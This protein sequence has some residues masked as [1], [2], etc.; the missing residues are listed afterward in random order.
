MNFAV[1]GH[2]ISHSLSPVMHHANFR[3][4]GLDY[5]YLAL[6]IH[7]NHFHHIRD[8]MTAKEMDGFNV[9]IP[10]KTAIMDYLDEVD[11]DALKM[12]A[13]NTVK[14]TGDKWTGYNTDASG[15]IES[16]P[17]HDYRHVL[18]IGAG[19]ASRAIAQGFAARGAEVTVANRSPERLDDWPFDV[20]KI[21]LQDIERYADRTDL[22]VNTTPVG[23]TGFKD[24]VL[25]D[26][27][28]VHPDAVVADIIYTPSKTPFLALADSLGL[29]TINGLGMFVNQG[30]QSF[31]IWTGL[32]ADRAAMT[33]C[34]KNHL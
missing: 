25:Y 18:L 24:E 8:I 15:F 30:A 12:G 34:V 7:P 28:S 29:T 3:S 6:D 22:L 23:M 9:T 11:A 33:E 19:G 4:L 31:K 5:S 2:P 20:N 10:F 32:E 1:I 17:L 27:S 14:I 13:V 26:F 21:T 16:L